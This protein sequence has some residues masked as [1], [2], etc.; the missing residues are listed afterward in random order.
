KLVEYLDSHGIQTLVH[1]P[2]PPHKQ[3]AYK[4]WN[5]LK[6][7]ITE[8]IHNTVL[9]I[10]LDPTMSDNEVEQVIKIINGFGK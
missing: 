10:P 4:D 8:D 5:N 2:I 9:S 3:I 1:Y 6:F 7:P